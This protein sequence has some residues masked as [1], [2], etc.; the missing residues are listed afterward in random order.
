MRVTAPSPTAPPR[1]PSRRWGLVLTA[2]LLAVILAVAGLVFWTATSPPPAPQI[3][4]VSW[5]PQS[6]GPGDVITVVARV[7]PATLTVDL[8]GLSYFESGWSGGGS[9]IPL[10]DGRFQA[11]IGPFV[12]GAEVWFVVSVST[13]EVG[14]TLSEHVVFQ[15]GQVL[16]GGPSGIRIDSVTL[17]PALPSVLD[18]PVVTARVNSSVAI[19]QVEFASMRFQRGGGGGGSGRAFESSPGLYRGDFGP[20]GPG[21]RGFE[22]GTVF[23][24][25]FAAR[26]ATGNTAV[27]E[28]QTFVVR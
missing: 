15:V 14:P 27:S 13:R 4:A 17:D 2:A 3:L 12:E 11:Q 7:T 21:G 16:R 28:I 1:P 22:R 24:Y 26:D 18:N 20:A 6:P 25:R 19:T 9:M 10:G 23:F 5:T 8:Q